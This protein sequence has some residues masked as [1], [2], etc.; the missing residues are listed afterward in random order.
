MHCPQAPQLPQVH[1]I[2]IFK[3]MGFEYN[4][5][6][7]LIK[8]HYYFRPKEKIYKK[9]YIPQGRCLLQKSTSTVLCPHSSPPKV[10]G[11][12]VHDLVLRF[13]AIGP[14]SLVAQVCEQGDQLVHSPQEPSNTGRRNDKRLINL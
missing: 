6:H 5:K 10:G 9:L 4:T 1:G 11:G 7:A 3:K 14:G 13:V 2:S 12:S 8:K